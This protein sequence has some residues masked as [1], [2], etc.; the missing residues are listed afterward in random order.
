MENSLSEN[1]GFDFSIVEELIPKKVRFRDKDGGS[2]DDMKVDLPSVHSIS[3]KD[4]LFGSKV[5]DASKR[6]NEKEDIDFL[7]GDIQKTFVNGVPSITFSDR[8]HHI[9]FQGMENIVVLKLLGRKYR[10]FGVAKQNL[11]YVETLSTYSHDGH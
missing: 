7:E 8:I 5:G 1:L 11:Q 9:L 3:W 10:F 4:M 6:T 2:N